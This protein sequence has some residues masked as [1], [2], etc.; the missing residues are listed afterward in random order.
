MVE[1]IVYNVFDHDYQQA[2]EVKNVYRVQ[3]DSDTVELI[4]VAHRYV[5][6]RY[7]QLQNHPFYGEPSDVERLLVKIVVVTECEQ[8]MISNQGQMLLV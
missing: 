3:F 1:K 7:C 5:T 4:P 8:K 6:W 2:M